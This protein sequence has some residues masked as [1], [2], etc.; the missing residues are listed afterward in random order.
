MKTELFNVIGLMSGTSIDGIDA[1]LIQTDGMGHVRALSTLLTPYEAAFRTRM[2]RH[3]GNQ[4]GNRDPEVAAFEHEFTELHAGIVERFRGQIAGLV[5]AVD[6]IGFH[7]QTIW[8]QPKTRT[9][10]Q[11]G[12]GAMLAERTGIPVICDFRSADVKAGGNGAPLV[13]LYHRALVAGLPKPVAILN[14]GGVSNITW[15]GGDLDT[16]IVAYDVGPGNAL[17]DDWMLHAK[18]TAYDEHGA[19]AASG[20]IDEKL[21]KRFLDQPFFRR[22]PPKSLDR[23]AFRGLMPE[24]MTAADGAATLTR[25]TAHA[26]ADSLRFCPQKPLRLYVTGGGRLNKTLMQWIADLTA[27]PV[28]PVEDLGW[29]GDGLEAEA[30]AYLAVRSKLGLPLSMPKTT[31]V[32]QPM[33]GGTLHMPQDRKKISQG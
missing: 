31:G 6:L 15:I 1:A 2:R 25:I 22:K 14:I 12:D 7:G 4:A 30:F 18:G 17:I 19:L 16:D 23:D 24:G 27:I 13:P 11:L 3:F 29:S 10:I 32:P 26:A 9:T 8:H 20:R 28:S 21:V 5:P 33:T